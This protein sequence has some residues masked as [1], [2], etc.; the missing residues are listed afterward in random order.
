MVYN[1]E[2]EHRPRVF[3]NRVLRR[4]AGNKKDEITGERRKLHTEELHD[5][6]SSTHN[7]RLIKSKRMRWGGHVARLG[8][9]RGAY[10]FWWGVVRERG[11]SKE[12]SIHGRI[13][14]KW[15]YNK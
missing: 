8:D 10:R 5:L 12:L 7:M 2:R 13:V 9:R 6:Y 14:L 1:N 4:I 15:I 11:H 3:E